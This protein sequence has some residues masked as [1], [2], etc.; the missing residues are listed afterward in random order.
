[1]NSPRVALATFIL[2]LVIVVGLD[3]RLGVGWICL[4]VG[5]DVVVGCNELGVGCT[6]LKL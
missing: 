5:F 3:D 6:M 4:D 2:N 1:M